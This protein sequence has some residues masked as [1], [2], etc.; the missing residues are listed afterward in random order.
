MSTVTLTRIDSGFANVPPSY[1]IGDHYDGSDANQSLAVVYSLPDGYR[2]G[3]S[4]LGELHVYAPGGKHCEIVAR[5]NG[6]P[7]IADAEGVTP[8]VRLDVAEMIRNAEER[9]GGPVAASRE[10]GI[11]H[12]TWQGYKSGARAM[13]EYI[14]RSILAHL[15]LDQMRATSAPLRSPKPG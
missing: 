11:A 14:R 1:A 12:S 8:L 13:P 9:W 2:V 7:A 4:V 3:E 6:E 5:K 15:E 10:L